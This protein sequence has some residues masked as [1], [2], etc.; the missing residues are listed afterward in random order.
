MSRTALALACSA[1]VLAPV[2]RATAAEEKA[3]APAPPPVQQT[4]AHGT[5]PDLNGRWIAVGWAELPG[6][7][8]MTLPVFWEIAVAD[9]KPTLT[10]RLAELPPDLKA[11]VDQANRE[12]WRWVPSADV[13]AQLARDWDTLPVTDQKVARIETQLTGPD[14]FEDAFKQDAHTKDATFVLSQRFDMRPDAAPV[15][16]QV[17]IY[18][19]ATQ[20]AD[21]WGGNFDD[22]TIAAAPF[23]IPI[24]VSGAFWMYRLGAPAAPKGFVARVLDAFAGCGR[25]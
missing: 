7:R 4:E 1:L 25:R 19:P 18:A 15:I 16:R 12:N 23:P 14:A 17:F 9:G 2:L 22:A 24:H 5:L 21:G 3:P 13:L 10:Q 6:G 20:T 11:G 8:T